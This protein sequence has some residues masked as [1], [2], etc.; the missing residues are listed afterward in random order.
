[1][2]PRDEIVIA[3]VQTIAPIMVALA[4]LLAAASAA[5]ISWGNRMNQVKASKQLE[6]VHVLVNSQLTTVKADLV[7]AQGR[8]QQ[9]ETLILSANEQVKELKSTI[10]RLGNIDEPAKTPVV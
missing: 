10:S 7:I 3:L 5:A 4:T 2:G 1:M 6:E 8:I 9:L